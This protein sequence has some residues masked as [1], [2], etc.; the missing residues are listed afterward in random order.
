VPVPLTKGGTP[1][2]NWEK[3]V[4]R[5]IEAASEGRWDDMLGETMIAAVVEGREYSRAAAPDDMNDA[6]APLIGQARQHLVDR[7]RVRIGIW[8][9]LL[10]SLADAYD[11]QQRAAGH[12]GF[13][14]IAD[15]LA[16]ADVLSPEGME[17]LAWRLDATIQSIALDEFQDTSVEQARVLS[18][19]LN[20]MFAGD[21]A[22]DTPRHM[23][24]VADPKQS[25]YGWR[26]GTPMLIEWLKQEGGDAL[27]CETIA[28]SW[29]SSPV[30][31]DFVN[32]CFEGLDTNAAM[33]GEHARRALAPKVLATACGLIESCPANPVDAALSRWQ[34]TPHVSAGPLAALAGQVCAYV[35]EEADAAG[36]AATIVSRRMKHACTIGI[37]CPTNTNV[38]KV[39]DALRAIDI[40]VSQEGSG[41]VDDIVAAARL[42]DVL[43][44]GEH[45][46]HMA[47]AYRVSHS[48]LGECLGL[49]P[50][51]TV[52]DRCAAVATVSSK[53]RKAI[54]DL[55]LPEML[56]ELID[57]VSS[58]VDQREYLALCRIVTIA[59][60]WESSHPR[61]L[62]D[63]V[64][65]VEQTGLGE[66]SSARVR[67]MTMH[68]S[69]GLEFDE[70]LLPWLDA[71]MV[72]EQS[73]ACRGW[74]ADPLGAITAI[75]PTVTTAE[76]VHT[77]VLRAF[78]EQAFAGD[79]ADRLS[80][81]YVAITRARCG[82]H[83]IFRP[84]KEKKGAVDDMLSPAT[85]LRAAIPDIAAA[86]DGQAATLP[87]P[88]W[89]SDGS[90]ESDARLPSDQ[91][92]ATA[93][94][95]PV[96][97]RPSGTPKRVTPSSHD[98][99]SLRTRCRLV[100]SDA[101]R[102]GV[103]LHELFRRVRW[104]EDARPDDASIEHAFDEAAI[105]LGQPVPADLR[106]RLRQRFESALDGDLGQALRRDAHANW[107][108]ASLTVLPEHP[109][110]VRLSDGVLQG[111]ID[112][113]VLGH[114]DTGTVTNAA[115]LDYKS[116]HISTEDDRAEAEAH[117][118]GQLKRYAQG[119]AAV[120]GIDMEAIQTRLL[121]VG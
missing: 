77:P 17:S 105:Q 91:L 48:P 92:A 57:G 79:L 6:L 43:R 75:A 60:S 51:E 31:M 53:I 108:A 9:S 81:L 74:S 7:L 39:A 85:F 66:A 45:P 35:A 28:K 93:A 114:D 119:V 59:A 103:I 30:I 41:K 55:G 90:S 23:L 84:I 50:L 2:K 44:V 117:Y 54:V 69:K 19:L 3:A 47:A 61:R 11:D 27:E 63:F 12:Y 18:P 110:L 32:A 86:L 95:E 5:V 20:E 21:G 121:F 49:P 97:L 4:P 24:V 78:H 62:S 87:T 100:S 106:N 71:K 94:A 104:L 70:V 80:L 42:L 89:R 15:R 38:A 73:P 34:F 101:R 64:T 120:W 25:I 37:L 40:P 46:G 26:G 67:V 98:A 36:I 88:I 116:G 107:K 14:D 68:A 10:G 65:H 115:I 113:L 109:V 52:P 82:L 22:Y 96:R 1:N 72:N 118:A 29:R 13:G 76:R 99:P 111:R 83:L 33:Q 58:R 56:A 102:D 8:R 112:R 16:R